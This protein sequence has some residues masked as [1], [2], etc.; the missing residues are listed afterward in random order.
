M[1]ARPGRVASIY[2]IDIP[3]PRPVHIQTRP[4]FIERILTIKAKIDHGR[5]AAIGVAIT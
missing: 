1:S 3:R 2:N 5:G 4:D